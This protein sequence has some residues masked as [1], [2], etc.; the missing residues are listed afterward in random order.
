[1]TTENKGT[2]DWITVPEFFKRHKGL[3]AKNFVYEAVKDGRIPGLRLSRK[4]IL[5]KADSF[6]I[7]FDSSQTNPA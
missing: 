4:K 1:M 3:V 7:L 2:P 6:D 5:I